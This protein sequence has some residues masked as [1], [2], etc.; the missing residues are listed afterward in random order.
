M[1]KQVV[2]LYFTLRSGA[3]CQINPGL[4]TVSGGTTPFV[5][6]QPRKLPLIMIKY[7]IG[8]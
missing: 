3:N 4:V 2:A 7:V 1:F 5:P 8:G 6:T